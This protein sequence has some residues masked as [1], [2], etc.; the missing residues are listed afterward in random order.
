MEQ[1]L[2]ERGEAAKILNISLRLLDYYISKKELA[3]RRLGRRVLISRSELERFAKH[4]HA[5]RDIR[6][7]K[8]AQKPATATTAA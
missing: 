1:L 8:N 5:G 7:R 4:D 3:A 6:P 2:Y